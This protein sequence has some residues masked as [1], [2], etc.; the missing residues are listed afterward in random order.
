LSDVLALEGMPWF[1][2]QARQWVSSETLGPDFLQV[3]NARGGDNVSIVALALELRHH[4]NVEHALSAAGV[5][6]ATA[7]SRTGTSLFSVYM[8]G[9]V[10]RSY[11]RVSDALHAE[12]LARF[13]TQ[14]VRRT[15]HTVASVPGRDELPVF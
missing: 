14:K 9:M 7:R 13:G 10:D 11:I 8:T 6:K 4:A 3:K 1:K 5:V 12:V 15:K 2:G